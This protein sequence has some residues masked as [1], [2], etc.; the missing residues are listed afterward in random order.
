MWDTSSRQHLRL[1]S[2]AARAGGSLHLAEFVHLV[3]QHHQVPTPA[4]G[5]STRNGPMDP[6]ARQAP[7]SEAQPTLA[8]ASPRRRSGE[9]F[10]RPARR[11]TSSWLAG[12]SRT[13][14]AGK[15]GE[16]SST[17]TST[18]GAFTV[19]EYLTEL[20]PREVLGD[21]GQPLASGRPFCVGIAPAFAC[22]GGADPGRAR[23]RRCRVR[24]STSSATCRNARWLLVRRDH[25]RA[26]RVA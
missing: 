4:S 19:A 25:G 14:C 2:R 6:A 10:E 18:R 24:R 11:M 12:K 9:G 5:G 21:T 17:W 26:R 8:P 20:P 7:R 16:R 13:L 23:R 1:C 3:G 22:S 15:N